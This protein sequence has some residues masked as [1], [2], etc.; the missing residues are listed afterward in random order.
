MLTYVPM[1]GILF[2]IE[3]GYVFVNLKKKGMKISES[4]K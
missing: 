1:S 3:T 4:I 2:C